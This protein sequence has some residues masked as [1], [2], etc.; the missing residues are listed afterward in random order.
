MGRCREC[1]QGKKQEKKQKKV[2]AELRFNHHDAVDALAKKCS[3]TIS[4]GK[5][6]YEQHLRAL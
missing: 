5:V 1:R 2:G 3:P 4:R 6:S